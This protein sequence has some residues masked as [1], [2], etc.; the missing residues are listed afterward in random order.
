MNYLELSIHRPNN[1][2]HLGI[3]RK[4]TQTDSTTHFTCNCPLE[5][6]FAVYMFY[7]NRTITV[8][9]TKQAKQQEWTTMLNIAGNN[10]FPLHIIHNIK[11]KAII[12]TQQTKKHTNTSK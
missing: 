7:I 10:G 11:N 9:I 5:Q 8:P 12:K 6:K 1:K 4:P 3:Y 2:L